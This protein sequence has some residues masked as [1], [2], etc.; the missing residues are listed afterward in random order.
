MAIKHGRLTLEPI[1]IDGRPYGL[2]T[3]ADG[4]LWK[5]FVKEKPGTYF[6]AVIDDG[7]IISAEPDPMQSL[8]TGADIWQI[9]HAGPGEELRGKIWNGKKVCEPPKISSDP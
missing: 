6:I 2:P 5:D 1:V 8:V 7:T 9:K 3:A 4:T